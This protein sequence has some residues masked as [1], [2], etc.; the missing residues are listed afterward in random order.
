M[1]ASASGAATSA[2]FSLTNTAPTIALAPP[3]LPNGAAEQAYSQQLTASGTGSTAP[4]TFAVTTGAL[5]AGLT[6]DPTG[7]LHGTPTLAGSF[8]FTVTATDAN[9]F[10]GTQSYT[11]VL[12]APTVVVAPTSLPA[13]VK[14]VAY[15]AATITAAGG[16]APYTFAV[17]TGTLPGG[18]TLDPTHGHPLRHADGDGHV[19]LHGDGD[20]RQWLHGHAGNTRSA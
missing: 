10:T 19:R 14:G 1:T 2:T 8:P 3:T 5:P 17:T 20:R 12:T 16:V 6:L 9:L 15:P 7:L 18:L 4:Y 13:G 11:L